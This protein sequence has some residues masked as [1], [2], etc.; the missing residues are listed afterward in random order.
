MS[1]P[2]S[3]GSCKC[4]TCVVACSI[5]MSWSNLRYHVAAVV[6]VGLLGPAAAQQSYPFNS[7]WNRVG[8]AVFYPEPGTTQ[9][10][11]ELT[12]GIGNQGGA[13]RWQQPRAR[14]PPLLSL[15]SIRSPPFRC[16]P[17]ASL[18]AGLVRNVARL[19]Q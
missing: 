16:R 15:R 18:P 8:T 17:L 7:A 6:L 9:S 4:F 14:L 12:Q 11:V 1:T 13:V 3:V 10:Y 2:R 19:R 5:R